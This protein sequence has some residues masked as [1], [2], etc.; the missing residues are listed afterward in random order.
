LVKCS[1]ESIGIVQ[2]AEDLGLN[3]EAEVYV[4][5]WAALGVVSREGAGKL[6][7]VRV[8]QLWVQQRRQIL[9]KWK[10]WLLILGRIFV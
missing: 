10:T 8:G 3:Y 4:D 9:L 2:L 1:S 6:R 7:H 5:S